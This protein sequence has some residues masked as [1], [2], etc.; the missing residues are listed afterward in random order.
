MNNGQQ[1]K[2]K[3]Y[4]AEEV[5]LVFEGWGLP[6]M[7]GRLLGWLLVCEP[8]HQSMHELVDA[9]S[10]SKASI[11]NTTRMLIEI[12]LIERISLPEYRYDHYRIR[13]DAWYQM[14]K[15]RTE[16]L[17]FIRQLA[18]RGLALLK[19]EDPSLSCR[20]QDMRDLYVFFEQEFPGIL[21]RW[22]QRKSEKDM[23]F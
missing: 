5:G 7:A 18:E 9:L 17:T 13:A 15:R 19:D 10:A 14:A 4:F 8:P 12:G 1:L 11:S 2:K 21:E 20:L 16:Q 6:R 23:E 3:K 22:K